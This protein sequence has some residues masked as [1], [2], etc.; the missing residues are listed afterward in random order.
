MWQIKY[1]A[2]KTIAGGAT[3]GT[4]NNIIINV[5]GDFGRRVNLNNS[6]G[7]DHG[8][9]QNLFTLGGAGVVSA[10]NPG[11]AAPRTLGKI[12]GTTVRVGA[13]GTNNQ[14]TEPTPGS[15]EFEP[16]SVASSLYSYPGVQNPDTITADTDMN[17]TGDPAIDETAT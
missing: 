6:Q 2:G 4:T 16:M 5:F 7:W 14:V 9:N 11:G 10:G 12:V 3:R 15:Y 13:S 1:S 8:N 17:P